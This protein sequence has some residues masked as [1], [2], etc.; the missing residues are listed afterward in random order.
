MKAITCK[1]SSW[2]LGNVGR[3]LCFCCVDGDLHCLSTVSPTMVKDCIAKSMEDSFLFLGEDER[4]SFIIPAIGYYL[5][6]DIHVASIYSAPL[7]SSPFFDFFHRKGDAERNISPGLFPMILY[8]ATIHD[9]LETHWN[10][11]CTLKR[12]GLRMQLFRQTRWPHISVALNLN[13]I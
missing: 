9:R 12:S 4:F 5:I 13:P 3:Y 10:N 8:L 7:S 11:T 1:Q 2:S 6:S